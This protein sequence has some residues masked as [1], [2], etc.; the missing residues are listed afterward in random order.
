MDIPSPDLPPVRGFRTLFLWIVAATFVA[1]LAAFATGR[2]DGLG[3]AIVE[4]FK[5]SQTEAEI[6]SEVRQLRQKIDDLARK[7]DGLA[8]SVGPAT[9]KKVSP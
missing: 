3:T 9:K 4:Q 6:T 1:S 8:E 2:F 7:M 5:S